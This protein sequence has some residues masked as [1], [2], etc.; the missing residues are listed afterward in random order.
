MDLITTLPLLQIHI[1]A[2]FSTL[3]IVI[4][5]D[6]HGLLWVLGKLQTISQKKLD[7]FHRLTWFGLI[8]IIVAGF[9]MFIGYPEYLLSLTAFKLKLVFLLFLVINAIFI[10]KHLTIASTRTFV[11]LSTKEKLQLSISGLFSV[12]GWIGAYSCAQFLS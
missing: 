2:V 11:S 6:I 12:S 10:G 7:L 5:A 1:A 4:I 8:I 9:L 3:I